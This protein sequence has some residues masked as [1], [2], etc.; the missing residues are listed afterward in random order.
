MVVEIKSPTDE[1]K[2]STAAAGLVD[3]AW[4]HSRRET[5]HSRRGGTLVDSDAVWRPRGDREGDGLAAG[6]PIPSAPQGCPPF[7]AMNCS[8][9]CASAA[10]P[11]MA[12]GGGEVRPLG[13]DKDLA[14]DSI[15]FRLEVARSSSGK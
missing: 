6:D 11:A 4:V 9:V 14:S 1:T 3:P 2:T 10:A 13:R 5:D 8:L 15:K 12:V 7:A